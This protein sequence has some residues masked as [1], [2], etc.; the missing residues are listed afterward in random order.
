MCHIIVMD[1]IVA[2]SRML[3]IMIITTEESEDGCDHMWP[4]TFRV[5]EQCTSSPLSAAVPRVCSNICRAERRT[6]P[7]R[8]WRC[9][10]EAVVITVVECRVLPI[11]LVTVTRCSHWWTRRGQ[12]WRCSQI[13]HRCG[14]PATPWSIFSWC[15]ATAAATPGHVA[16]AMAA[17]QVT[18]NSSTLGYGGIWATAWV[19]R[20]VIISR[21][22]STLDLLIE[23]YILCPVDEQL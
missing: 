18:I 5:S 21:W 4:A 8:V 9:R 6:A 16:S 19:V 17:A 13:R 10:K 11:L 3:R 7:C 12:G 1:C 15:P 20:Q 2:V 14:T 23:I 22:W